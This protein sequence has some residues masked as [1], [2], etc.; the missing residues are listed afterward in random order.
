MKPQLWYRI[1][2]R[3][4]GALC[5]WVGK[6][7]PTKSFLPDPIERVVRRQIPRHRQFAFSTL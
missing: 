4:V 1:D 3:L 2:Q 7:V 5:H 6:F